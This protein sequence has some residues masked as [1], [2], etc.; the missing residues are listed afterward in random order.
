M[1]NNTTTNL[2]YR[3]RFQDNNFS[4]FQS[5]LPYKTICSPAKATQK[6]PIFIFYLN[7]VK[8]F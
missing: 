2:L 6:G 1:Q 4:H 5:N 7:S 8:M 3:V